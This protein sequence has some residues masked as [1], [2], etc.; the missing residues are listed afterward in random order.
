VKYFVANL[1]L[2]V[3]WAALMGTITVENLAFGFVLGYLLLAISQR[4]LGPTSYFQRLPRLISFVIFYLR[5]MTVANLK[6]AA[7][8]VTPQTLSK[9]AILAVPLDARTDLEITLFAN[10]LALTPGTL[11][12]DLSPDRQTLY[13]HALFVDDPEAF[14]LH[15]KRD[16]E[17]RVLE[18]VRA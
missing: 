7:E 18:L 3:A 10:L 8:V 1:L 4:A 5:E 11:A 9:P 16:L 12:I 17:R 13:V 15:I 2:A 6:V 14:K